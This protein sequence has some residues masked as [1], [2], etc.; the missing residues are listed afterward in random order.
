MGRLIKFKQLLISGEWHDGC[1]DWK[2][3]EQKRRD[4]Y[5][6]TLQRV[7]PNP[8]FFIVEWEGEAGRLNQSYPLEPYYSKTLSKQEITQQQIESK[9]Q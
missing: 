8:K 2:Y 3:I 9:F 1:C 7:G 6:K 5:N 4:V